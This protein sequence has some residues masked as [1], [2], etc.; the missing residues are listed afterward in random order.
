MHPSQSCAQIPPLPDAALL[1]GA[2]VS[3][4]LL[5]PEFWNKDRNAALVS[6]G[7]AGFLILGSLSGGTQEERGMMVRLC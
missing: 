6:R 7:N 3:Q 4:D 2:L 1:Q 5:Q